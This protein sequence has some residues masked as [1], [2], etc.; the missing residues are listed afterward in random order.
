MYAKLLE[1]LVSLILGFFTG[2]FLSGGGINLE[3]SG[4]EIL[5]GCLLWISIFAYLK[6]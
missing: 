6:K 1:V 2:V 5:L 4:V 3:E